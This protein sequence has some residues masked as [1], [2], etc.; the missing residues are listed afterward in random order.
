[1]LQESAERTL[2]RREN[3]AEKREGASAKGTAKRVIES[4]ERSIGGWPSTI[5]VASVSP[6]AGEIESPAT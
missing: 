3:A 6:S 4:G 2:R 1:V 5:Q